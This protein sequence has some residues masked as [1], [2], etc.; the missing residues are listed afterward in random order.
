MSMIYILEDD[1]SIR[2]L[3]IYTLHAT[4]F[5]AKGFERPSLFWETMRR[6]QPDLLLL[7]IMLPEEDGLSVLARLRTTPACEN[8]PVILLTAKSTEFDKVT[9]LDG[10]ADDYITKPF[11]M[12]ELIS[13]IKALLRRSGASGAGEER[14]RNDT[15]QIGGLYVCTVTHTIKVDGEPVTLTVKEFDLLCCLLENQG[16]VLS[17]ERLHNEVWGYDFG[18]ESRTLDVHIRTLRQKLGQ[19][20]D[21]IQTIRG[22][23]YKIDG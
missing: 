17:R 16:M 2:E 9:G 22:V 12:M 19:A 4:G 15:W 20:G 3:V 11:G 1:H 14:K 6:E 23:G 5:E 18:G 8:L 7:D 10:G 21:L 13:R